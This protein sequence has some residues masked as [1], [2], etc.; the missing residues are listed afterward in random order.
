MRLKNPV[1]HRAPV[2]TE[3]DCFVL[4]YDL[5]REKTTVHRKSRMVDCKTRVSTFNV[6]RL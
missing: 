2:T 5:R 1:E 4:R 6:Y 3:K